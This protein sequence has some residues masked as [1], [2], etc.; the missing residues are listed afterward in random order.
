MTQPTVVHA[1][2]EFRHRR[3]AAG[4]ALHGLTDFTFGYGIEYLE[5]AVL[6]V[7]VA[8]PVGNVG[9]HEVAEGLL[10]ILALCDKVISTQYSIEEP[11]GRRTYAK[12]VSLET[13]RVESVL[14]KVD[15]GSVDGKRVR[16][17][18][19]ADGFDVE[20]LANTPPVEGCH[21]LGDAGVEADQLLYVVHRI[22]HSLLGDLERP[23]DPLGVSRAI[24]LLL[25]QPLHLPILRLDDLLEGASPSLDH[26][27]AVLKSLV[28]VGD[29]LLTMLAC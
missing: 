8:S 5:Q 16:L 2:L 24:G 28:A 20:D 25:S 18:A 12:L 14:V 11:D 7:R 1:V 6:W 17:V 15:V 29:D 26:G 9:I 3:V 23:S 22:D 4:V 13:S 19:D 21:E 27:G 10:V